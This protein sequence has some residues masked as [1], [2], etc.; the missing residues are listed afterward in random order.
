MIF[1]E[2]FYGISMVFSWDSCGMNFYWI[3]MRLLWDSYGIFV[4]TLGD[5][6]GV[7][8]GIP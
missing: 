2:D 8:I 3:C 1:K 7:P 5:L 6:F 4:I